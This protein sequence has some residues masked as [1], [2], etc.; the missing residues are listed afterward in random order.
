MLRSSPKVARW[1]ET[2]DVLVDALARLHR[3][4]ENVKLRRAA[5][6]TTWP[7]QRDGY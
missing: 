5:T 2:D 7:C 4:L 3:S 1:E 6:T